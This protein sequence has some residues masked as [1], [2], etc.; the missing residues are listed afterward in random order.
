MLEFLG[1]RAE[2][3]FPIVSSK[4][5]QDRFVERGKFFSRIGFKIDLNNSNP[6]ELL[7]DALVP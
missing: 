1:G 3:Y 7:E 4:N 5:L 6:W 2:V